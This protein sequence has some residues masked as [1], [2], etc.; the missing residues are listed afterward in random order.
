MKGWNPGKTQGTMKGLEPGVKCSVCRKGKLEV[1]LDSVEA[2][3]TTSGI[4]GLPISR[5]VV[6]HLACSKCF[7]IFEAKD[8]GCTLDEIR[9]RQLKTFKNPAKRPDKCPKCG[10]KKWS[11]QHKYDEYGV[12]RN[13]PKLWYIYCA[14]CD[15]IYWDEDKHQADLHSEKM[16]KLVWGDK[17]EKEIKKEQDKMFEAFKQEKR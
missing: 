16:R 17:S 12:R 3:E 6:D 15:T 10:S 14:E 2:G 5:T 11:S 4:I 7:L 1:M 13:V 9:E 8:R